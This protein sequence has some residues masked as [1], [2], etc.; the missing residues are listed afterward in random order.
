MYECLLQMWPRTKPGNAERTFCDRAGKGGAGGSISNAALC[1]RVRMG[2]GV[3]GHTSGYDT[4]LVDPA[5]AQRAAC[6]AP[7]SRSVCIVCRGIRTEIQRRNFLDAVQTR[8][9]PAHSAADSA[10]GGVSN[11]GACGSCD[12]IRRDAG[13]PKVRI[14]PRLA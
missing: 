8:V 11:A 13:R 4:R 3:L 14:Q 5:S 9:S 10:G 7:D 6:F 1:I 12:V 2:M